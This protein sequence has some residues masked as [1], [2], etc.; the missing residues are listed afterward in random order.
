MTNGANH[1]GAVKKARI[2]LDKVTS[3]YGKSLQDY[4]QSEMR[5]I[6]AEARVKAI[7]EVIAKIDTL[8]EISQLKAKDAKLVN[9]INDLFNQLTKVEQ[10]EVTNKQVLIDAKKQLSEVK[11]GTTPTRT[12]GNYGTRKPTSNNRRTPTKA[13]SKRKPLPKTGEVTQNYIVPLGTAMLGSLFFWRKKE[14]KD[15]LL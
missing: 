4:H 15:S 2:E 5:L 10:N 9:E 13:V 3:S 8:P 11:G 1:V 12:G 7:E 6:E 14:E